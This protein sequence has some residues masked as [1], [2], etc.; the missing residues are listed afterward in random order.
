[1]PLAR[2]AARI[3]REEERREDEERERRRSLWVQFLATTFTART[4][5]EPPKTKE[6]YEQDKKDQK[7]KTPREPSA[8]EWKQQAKAREQWEDLN[9]AI[10]KAAWH[11][12]H[13]E[14]VFRFPGHMFGEPPEV[15]EAAEDTRTPKEREAIGQAIFVE[16]LKARQAEM[17]G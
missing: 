1:M 14:E 10:G 9:N 2:V 5:K 17:T 6:E 16:K 15:P 3:V 13:F 7:R 4:D 11:P 8:K 12:A